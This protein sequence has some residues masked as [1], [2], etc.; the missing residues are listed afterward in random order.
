MKYFKGKSN[1]VITFGILF[2][3]VAVLLLLIF[4]AGKK[5]YVV[6]FDLDGGA[7]ISGSLE[8]HVTQGQDATPPVAVKDGAYL[9]TWSASYRR[10]TKN[11]VI[12]AIWEYET[13]KGIIYSDSEHQNFVEIVGAY[14]HLN[15]EVYLGA[16]HDEKK[17]LG[18][19][20]GAFS[21][22]AGITRIYLLDGL[23]HIGGEA[24]AGCTSLGEI[25]IPKTV[26]HLE[27][28][29]FRGCSSLERIVLNEGL[30][31][32]GE[33]AFAGCVGLR[34]IILPESLAYIGTD[35]FR[36]CEDLVIKV[37]IAEDEA[38]SGWADGWYGD[39]QIVWDYEEPVPEQDAVKQ[40]K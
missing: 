14:R 27:N 3:A 24:F 17:V 21:D 15:G 1:I 30:S 10:I 12:R 8:Q 37:R 35:A 33:N 38:P 40:E 18:I 16:Y 22:R 5:T 6:Q 13:T 25:E 31:H 36:G 9:R 11:I 19:R 23:I 20:D 7:L 28:G 26:T 32:L 4:F 39:A 29:V 34:E 2:L